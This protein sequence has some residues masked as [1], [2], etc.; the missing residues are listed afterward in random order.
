MK[1]REKLLNVG[2][3]GLT[4]AE[5]LAVLLQTGTHQHGVMS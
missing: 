3:V 1:P 4:D 5:L 2:A